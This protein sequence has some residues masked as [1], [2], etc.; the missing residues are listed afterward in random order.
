MGTIQPD[1]GRSPAGKKHEDDVP[2][3]LPPRHERIAEPR[4][5]PQHRIS[6]LLLDESQRRARAAKASADH[7][8]A[9]QQTEP[10]TENGIRRTI[11]PR[12]PA[13][14][15]LTL[16]R[17]R[18]QIDT[19]PDLDD[20]SWCIDKPGLYVTCRI[21][22]TPVATLVYGPNLWENEPERLWGLDR[23]RGGWFGTYA[24]GDI[25]EPG[26]Y[27]WTWTEMMAA[28]RDRLSKTSL[29]GA[30][31]EDWYDL[32][33]DDDTDSADDRNTA[34][35]RTAAPGSRLSGASTQSRQEHA[36][37]YD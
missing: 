15:Y 27:P 30:V 12:R 37:L 25:N 28:I 34:R 10:I 36:M 11:D 26:T 35:Q 8:P 16:D 3:P 18:F 14:E 32:E 23:P 13:I 21:C 1:R 22:G 2:V 31:T 7:R 6:A 9:A 20:G 33:V 4:K 5:R 29:A 17:P 19:W 24:I